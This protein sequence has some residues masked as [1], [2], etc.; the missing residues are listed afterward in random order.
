MAVANAYHINFDCDRDSNWFSASPVG[1]ASWTIN[2]TLFF[3][4][5]TLV[6]FEGS[7]YYVSP[8]HM[9]DIIQKHKISHVF[10]PASVIDEFQ[11]RGYVPT[12]KH[13]ISSLR[14]VLAGGSV[15]KPASYDFI[16]KI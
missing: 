9:W 5:N 12:D 15:V 8:T 3:L 13:D 6:L 16:M 4:G 10:F 14:L 2:V 7:P 1:W 11:K